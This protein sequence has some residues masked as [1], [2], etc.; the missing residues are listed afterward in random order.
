MSTIKI[1]CKDGNKLE[2]DTQ[3]AKKSVLLNNIIQDYDLNDDIPININSDILKIIFVYLE[4]YKDSEPEIIPKPLPSGNLESFTDKWD[5]DFID[6]DKSVV[7]NLIV[8]ANFMDIKSLL[9]LSCAKIA[10]IMKSMDP[11]TIKK[12]FDIPEDMTE[13]E[14][15]KLEEEEMK[16]FEEIV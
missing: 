11:E 6:L 9:E 8:A 1:V 2:I 14:Q 12:E 7:L 13:E 5:V 4:H 10:S 3:S 15:K 16:E